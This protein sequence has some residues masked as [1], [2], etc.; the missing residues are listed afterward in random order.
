MTT[1][2]VAVRFAQLIEEMRFVEAF[3]M[4]A[5]DGRY[6]VPGT[7][8][9]S[10]VYAGRQDLLDNLV[11]V[12]ST[13]TAPPQLRFQEP[14]V[15]GNRAALMAGGSGTGPTGPYHQPYYAFVAT[16]R[17]DEFSEIIEF[18]DLTML[19]TAVFGKRLVNA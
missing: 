18:M 8:P 15:D 7:T 12:L 14:I 11:P 1:R 5:A 13:F 4:L 3:S 2:N 16:V 6:I 17:G 19:E 10:R 9:V